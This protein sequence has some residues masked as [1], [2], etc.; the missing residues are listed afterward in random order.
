MSI[1]NM[2]Y[3]LHCEGD[4]EID[5]T[6]EFEVDPGEKQCMNPERAYP[7]TPP[8]I[9]GAAFYYEKSGEDYEL[10]DAWVKEHQDSLWRAIEDG[11]A[12]EILR[13]PSRELR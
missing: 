2:P 6:L 5:G 12:E 13:R 9:A 8:H 4:I 3:T 11:S 1:Y 7:G 10:S